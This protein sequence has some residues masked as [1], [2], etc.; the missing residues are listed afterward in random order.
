[1][2]LCHHRTVLAASRCGGD[3]TLLQWHQGS[4]VRLLTHLYLCLRRNAPKC[5]NRKFWEELRL[6]DG[7]SATTP[8]EMFDVCLELLEK[9]GMSCVTTANIAVFRPQTPGSSDGPRVWNN[10]LIRWVTL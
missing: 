3:G 9:A 10:Q 7:R 1:M 8:A 6:I 2:P 5:S 4:H